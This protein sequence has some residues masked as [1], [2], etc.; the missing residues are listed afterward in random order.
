MG[1]GKCSPVQKGDCSGLKL[2]LVPNER[3]PRF[4]SLSICG[5]E[6]KEEEMRFK[7]GVKSNMKKI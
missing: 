1:P 2:P 5:T 6:E 7:S 4:L 3:A